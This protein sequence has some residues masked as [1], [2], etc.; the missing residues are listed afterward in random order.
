MLTRDETRAE[1]IEAPTT[2]EE[3][4]PRLL[5]T[6]DQLALWGNLGVSVLLPVTATF[7][8][9][10]DVGLPAL[11]LLGALLAIA[12]GTVIGNVLLGLSA[13][14]GAREG[15]P[16]MVLLRGLL[17]RTGSYAPTLLNIVQCVG[18][19]TFEIVIIAEAAARLTDESLRWLFVL[20]AG[21][22]AVL[23]AVRPLKAVKTLKRY[24]I[25]AVIASTV[26][27]VVQIA[28]QPMPDFTNGSWT[29]FWK[30]TD[31]IVAMS[32]SWIPLAADYSR[33]SRKGSS[34]F[35]G[36]SVGYGISSSVMFT[37]G[38]LALAAY[39]LQP[40]FDVIDAILAVPAGAIALLILAIDE[41]DEA[42]ANIYSTA[43]STQNV[44]PRVDRRMLA[45]V[46]GGLA[47]GLALMFDIVAYEGF[48]FLIGSVFVPLA[49][50]FVAE[51][52]LL[53]RNSDW[54]TDENAPNRWVMAVPWVTGFVVYQLL[55]PGIVGWWQR[56]WVARQQDLG[57]TPPSWAS[58]TLVSFAVAFAFTCAIGLLRRVGQPSWASRSSAE[59]A[60]AKH[61]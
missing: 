23:M 7:I 15:V 55:N 60:G 19:A 57:F 9:A 18:W 44:L 48:L 45:A 30:S 27:L 41:V 14:A 36:S 16:A 22:L 59:V 20:L 46:I 50:V 54:R 5:G 21:G 56:F 49:A 1:T 37:M 4:A 53:A 32:V 35:I 29:A 34:A 31:L 12:L 52:F 6:G 3:P 58:A 38:V 2:L 11:S 10:P 39:G 42:F 61:A 13:L 26:Y 40:G 17:G 25:W 33:H 8:V 24:A 47:I 28:R 43:I 51:Y